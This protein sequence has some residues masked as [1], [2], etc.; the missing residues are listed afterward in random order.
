MSDDEIAALDSEKQA[1]LHS[2]HYHPLNRQAGVAILNRAGEEIDLRSAL[3]M[4]GED[5]VARL[6][7]S[8]KVKILDTLTDSQLQDLPD[9]VVKALRS[10]ASD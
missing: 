7:P 1:L 6:P 10:S 5:G 2:A 9:S 8:I 4:F 3:E